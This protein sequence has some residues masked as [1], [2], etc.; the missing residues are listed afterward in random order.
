MEILLN[1]IEEKYGK[2]IPQSEYDIHNKEFHKICCDPTL[3][4]EE[5][6]EKLKLLQK[7]FW[8]KHNDRFLC[9]KCNFKSYHTYPFRKHLES[10]KHSSKLS[11][12][13]IF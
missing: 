2:N 11:P 12:D 8:K 5:R 13:E 10:K 3:K 1:L 4:R 6:T 9:T 7:N